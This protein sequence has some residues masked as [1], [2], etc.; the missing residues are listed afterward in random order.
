MT[1]Q[2][3]VLAEVAD[4]RGVSALAEQLRELAGAPQPVV[5]DASQLARSDAS[6]LQLLT[7]FVR[8]RRPRGL[9]VHWRSGARLTEAARLLGLEGLLG[10]EAVPAPEHD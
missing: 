2:V 6:T 1:E 8:E 5:V 10:L 7:A 3:V 9:A 4:I